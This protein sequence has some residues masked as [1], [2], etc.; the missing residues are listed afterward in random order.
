VLT[1]DTIL[2]RGT[3]VVAHPDGR[4][5]DYL[6]SLARLRALADERAGL[7]LLTGHG[8]VRDDALA[9]V[10]FYLRHRAE[11]LAEVAAAVDAGAETAMDVVRVV[12][13]DVDRAVWPYA[14]LSVRAQLE[15]LAA[16]VPAN[17]PGAG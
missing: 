1:G 17:R 12:Y 6:A 8:P 13:A 11:R 16:Q 7:V 5:A 10:D 2:G 9:V 15:H 3:T 4:L 14:E